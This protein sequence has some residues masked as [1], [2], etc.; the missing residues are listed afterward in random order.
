MGAGATSLPRFPAYQL[1]SVVVDQLRAK[2]RAPATLIDNLPVAI[3]EHPAYEES[4]V[5]SVFADL[6]DVWPL[7]F[8]NV[9]NQIIRKSLHSVTVSG[10]AF[11]VHINVAGLAQIALDIL[12]EKAYLDQ[13]A[14][15][16]K[17]P[18]SRR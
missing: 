6:D 14:V 8:T 5:I 4:A 9:R 10:Q 13:I 3:K 1:E 18:N 7:L 16:T 11:V 2:L 17:R 12:K 15:T